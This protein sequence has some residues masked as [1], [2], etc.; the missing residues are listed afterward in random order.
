MATEFSCL[1][2]D[3]SVAATEI[4]DGWCGSCGKKLPASFQ[5]AVKSSG[6]RAAV[7]VMEPVASV[8]ERIICGGIS[9]ALLSMLAVVFIQNIFS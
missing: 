5:E 2:C 6:P 1:H 4:N 3:A 8:R 9:A 7:V